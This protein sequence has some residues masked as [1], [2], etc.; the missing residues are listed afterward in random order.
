MPHR[1]REGRPQR[2]ENSRFAGDS[3]TSTFTGTIP[4]RIISNCSAA[5][6]DK[7]MIRPQMNGPRSLIR[8]TT[9][10]LL[11]RFVTLTLEP[12]GSDR[13][14]AVNLYISKISPFAVFL[15]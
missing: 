4:G 8:T 11:E 3:T 1:A 7:S 10:R 9:D 13:C 15:P 6:W 5:A 12:N 14:A 2:L